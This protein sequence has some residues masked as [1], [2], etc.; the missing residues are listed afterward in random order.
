MSTF[1]SAQNRTPL[2]SSHASGWSSSTPSGPANVRR[3]GAAESERL[4]DAFR[5]K[6]SG[7]SSP[8]AGSLPDAASANKENVIWPGKTRRSRIVSKSAA[9]TFLANV[10]HSADVAR[11]RSCPAARSSPRLCGNQIF[12]PTSM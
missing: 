5:A 4:A 6:R 12:N 8:R 1:R 3:R 9:A 11:N 10:R 2:S 7:A